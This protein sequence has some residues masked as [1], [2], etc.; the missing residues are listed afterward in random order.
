[1]PETERIGVVTVTYN[2][3]EVIDDFW[4]SLRVQTYRN[5][6]LFVIDNA[7]GDD[8]RQK[9]RQYHDPRIVLIANDENNGGTGGDNQGIT[10]ALAAGCDSVLLL[11]NDTTFEPNLIRKL[12][13]GLETYDCQMIA[14]KMLFHDRPRHLW[15]AGG[16]FSL[17]QT[18][19]GVHR[20]EGRL[21]RGQFDEVMQ[22]SYCPTCCMLI[23]RVVFESI[24]IMDE[25]YFLYWDDTDLCL[26][27]AKA[28][29]TLVYLPEAVLWHKVS[30][31]TGGY[32][33]RAALRYVVRNRT[34]FIRKNVPP[35]WQPYCFL[36]CFFR[37]LLG[38]LLRRDNLQVFLLRQKWFWE[39]WAMPL[40]S[41]PERC[42][43]ERGRSRRPEEGTVSCRQQS[44]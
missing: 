36:F 17:W 44:M 23:R 9:I 18:Y 34:Y 19:A 8:T 41:A 25:N 7:S 29:F 37:S 35:V 6:L 12:V 13:A 16:R 21:D 22:V 27:A 24:G 30:S 3:G 38:L 33:S 39:G 32:Q 15:C 31:L 28:G 14:P 26:R 4:E 11:N 2:S 42:L 10:A 1:M 40:P 20:G 43:P 5:F